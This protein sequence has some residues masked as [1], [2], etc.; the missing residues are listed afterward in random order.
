MNYDLKKPCD[1]CPF[2]K[3]GG[4]RLEPERALEIARYATDRQGA[5]F[6][7]HKTTRTVDGERK[8]TKDSQHCAGALIFAEKQGFCNQ[9]NRIMER[10]GVY[11]ASKLDRSTFDDV[12]DDETEMEEANITA[13]EDTRAAIEATKGPST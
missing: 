3:Q 10:I 6:A 8:P 2:L 5:T 1:N 13:K 9:A 4:V 12:F 11:D 7:C